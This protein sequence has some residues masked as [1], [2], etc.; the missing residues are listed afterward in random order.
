MDYNK[1]VTFGLED[2]RRLTARELRILTARQLSYGS[3]DGS[4]SMLPKVR[5]FIVNCTSKF[6]LIFHLSIDES[7]KPL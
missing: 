3:V 1:S 4:E 2:G 6:I 7:R 5:F